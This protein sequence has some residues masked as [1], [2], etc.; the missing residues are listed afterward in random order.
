MFMWLRKFL[1]EKQ[2]DNPVVVEAVKAL[3]LEHKLLEQNTGHL[4]NNVKLLHKDRKALAKIF[5]EVVIMV[6]SERRK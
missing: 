4:L 1:P 6:Q 2:K 5:D 3:E